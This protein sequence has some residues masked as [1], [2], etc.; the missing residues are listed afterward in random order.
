MPKG[1][2]IP[3]EI[4]KENIVTVPKE[5]IKFIETFQQHLS[6]RKG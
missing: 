2:K 3:I 4:N 1:K 6:Q 5:I